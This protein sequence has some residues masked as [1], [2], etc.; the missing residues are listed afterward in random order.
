MLMELD[1]GAVVSNISEETVQRIA[2]KG[3]TLQPSNTR[4]KS[5]SGD[6]ITVLGM[7]KV[8]V[9]VHTH[10]FSPEEAKLAKRQEKR[11]YRCDSPRKCS[12]KYFIHPTSDCGEGERSI[13]S[14]PELVREDP[15]TAAEDIQS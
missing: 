8:G 5:Y 7:A 2:G 4:L 14:W 3:V 13:P 6:I 15:S 9:T 1:T 12:A 10:L 11:N